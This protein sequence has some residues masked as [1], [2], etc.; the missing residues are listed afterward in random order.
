M[1]AAPFWIAALVATGVL[2]GGWRAA[3]Y[4]ALVMTQTVNEFTE[5]IL[6]DDD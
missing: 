1:P 2:L 5:A 4:Q 3:H 6:E